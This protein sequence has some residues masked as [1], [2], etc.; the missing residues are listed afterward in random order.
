M[1]LLT[2]IVRE[3]A[4]S[5]GLGNKAGALVAETIRILFNPRQGGLRGFLERFHE[6]GL[7]E[8]TQSWRG[9]TGPVKPLDG[10][11]LETIVGTAAITEAGRQLG[12]AN[13]RVRTAMAFA[14]PLLVRYFTAGG[15]VP[16][17]MPP[18]VEAF[19]DS[20]DARV[21]APAS[22]P[23]PRAPTPKAS[24]LSP[25][26]LGVL[27]LLA[28]GAL[29]GYE[30]WK[31]Q[32]RI[33]AVIEDPRKAIVA[34]APVPP[35][36]EPEPESGKPPAR[37]IIRNDSG[38]FEYAGVVSDAGMKANIV[39]Q[40]FTFY[41]Q[42]RLSGNLAIDPQVAVPGWLSRLDRVLPQLNVPG[43]DLRLEGNSVKLGGW[44]TEQ[45]RDSVLNSLKTA[46]GPGFRFGYLRDEETELAEDAHA[47]TR[48]ALAALPPGYQ[49]QDL[50]AALNQWVIRFLE[51]SAEFPE[52]GKDLAARAA[53]LL[54]TMAQPVMLEIGGHTDNQGNAP[55]NLK[56]SLERAKAVREVLMQSGVP[57]QMLQIKG[58]GSERPVAANDTPYGRFKNRRIEFR[59]AQLCEQARTCGLPEPVQPVLPA[60]EL[61]VIP[62][63]YDLQKPV[64]TG[65]EAAQPAGSAGVPG[66]ETVKPIKRSK[67]KPKPK[68][69]PPTEGYPD[70]GGDLYGGKAPAPGSSVTPKSALPKG[71]KWIPPLSK[72]VTP[73]KKPPA[74]QPG[75]APVKPDAT[76]KPEAPKPVAP[77]PTPKPKPKPVERKPAPGTTQDLF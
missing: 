12:L 2:D 3:T 25:W 22:K 55:A 66:D 57:E 76:K 13:A 61:P 16:K 48:A 14:V 23:T 19:L 63:H 7:D 75:K 40:L 52:E 72:P 41:G 37:L 24:H 39:E 51:G 17:A 29:M 26:T 71:G 54:K 53:D 43:L 49:G 31:H 9:G 33:K 38:R 8:L 45:D 32:G 36:P 42:A 62:E 67:P 59:V 30:L 44:L 74:T 47:Q 50:V 60:P 6:A 35:K 69:K 65:A 21:L 5:F 10:K 46:L 64:T 56:L 70:R 73:E 27:I 28:T 11:Q 77:K 1:A 68:P 15:T 20:A 58:Y 18:A 34:Q 4:E